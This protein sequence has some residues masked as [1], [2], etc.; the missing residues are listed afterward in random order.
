MNKSPNHAWGDGRVAF[1]EVLE[2]VRVAVDRGR[3]LASIYREH[4]G[5][6]GISYR[7]FTTYVKR[8]ITGD[9]HRHTRE[10]VQSAPAQIRESIKPIRSD[11]S[12]EKE[13][14]SEID[15]FRHRVVDLDKLAKI[16]MRD[17]NEK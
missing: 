2:I 15:R 6:L 7:Q 8:F 14:P 11:S 13:T 4:Q 17:K 12:K 16:Y 10:V 3:P 5:H 9:Q 1:K